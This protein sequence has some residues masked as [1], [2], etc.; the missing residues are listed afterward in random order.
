VKDNDAV[1]KRYVDRGTSG[2]VKLDGITVTVGV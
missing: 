1:T 2:N